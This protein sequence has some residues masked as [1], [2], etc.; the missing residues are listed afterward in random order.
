MSGE[1]DKFIEMA[2]ADILALLRAGVITP[3]EYWD[4][5]SYPRLMK[6]YERDKNV[7]P[8]RSKHGMMSFNR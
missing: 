8:R 4:R 2:R 5:Q 3:V 6:L 1:V 7:L